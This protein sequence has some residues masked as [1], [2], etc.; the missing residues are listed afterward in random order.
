MV[1]NLN[2]LQSQNKYII[3]RID[4]KLNIRRAPSAKKQSAI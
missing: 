4:K 2:N 1:K 3:M